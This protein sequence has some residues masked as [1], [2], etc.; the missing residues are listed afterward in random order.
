VTGPRPL[1]RQP[2]IDSTA[3]PVA[4]T[5]ELFEPA[6]LAPAA[7]GICGATRAPL[8][9]RPEGCAWEAEHAGVARVPWPADCLAKPD[10]RTMEIPY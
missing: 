2:R 1:S 3:V 10:P 4:A 5:L 9:P 7:C 6:L 8:A